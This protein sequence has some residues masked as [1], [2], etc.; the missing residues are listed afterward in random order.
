V[1]SVHRNSPTGQAAHVEPAVEPPPTHPRFP[2]FDA[3]RATAALTI[4]AYHALIV[5][6]TGWFGDVAAQ[7]RIGV[8]VFF[9]ISGF[10]LYR[11]WLAARFEGLRAPTVGGYARSRAL[12]ILPAYWFALTVLAAKPSWTFVVGPFTDDWWRYYGLAQVYRAETFT[13]G[14]P[15]AW[16]LSVELSFYALLPCWALALARAERRLEPRRAVRVEAAA[17]AG[18]FLAS[19]AFRTVADRQGRSPLDLTLPSLLN[20]FV[21]GMALALAS[22]VVHSGVAREPR[23]VRAARSHPVACWLGAGAAFA[24]LVLL[25]RLPADLLVEVATPASAVLSALFAALFLVPA[26]FD[27][28]AGGLPRRVLGWRWLGWLGLI[29]YGIYLWHAALIPALAVHDYGRWLPVGETLSKAVVLAVAVTA[30]AAFSFYV[31]ER[32]LLRLKHPRRRSEG[33]GSAPPAADHLRASPAGREA[34]GGPATQSP[35]R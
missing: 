3:A 27:D 8:V 20:W 25:P 11:P 35:K 7:L 21:V 16:T 4:V 33:A 32:P 23:L 29:S 28:Q 18:L 2:L 14:L 26:V 9:V 34:S 24:A 5:H 13:T 31:V 10:L 1:T 6:R 12:R 22:V 17:L 19:L 30:A 15:V